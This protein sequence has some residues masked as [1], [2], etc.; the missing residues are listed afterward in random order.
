MPPWVLE[1][2]GGGSGDSGDEPRVWRRKDRPS[3]LCETQDGSSPALVRSNGGARESTGTGGDGQRAVEA[4][5]ARQANSIS[6]EDRDASK[7]PIES[8]TLERDWS[9]GAWEAGE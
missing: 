7:N 2:D 9:D 1:S 8:P 5:I 6:G 3:S 4:K